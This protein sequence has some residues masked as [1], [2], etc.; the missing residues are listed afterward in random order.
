MK[1]QT[2]DLLNKILEIADE[3]IISELYAEFVKIYTVL[4]V[5]NDVKKELGK[6]E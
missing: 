5:T 4:K 6:N 2:I 1:E 3:E